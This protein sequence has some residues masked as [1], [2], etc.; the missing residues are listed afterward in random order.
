MLRRQLHQQSEAH[1]KAKPLTSSNKMAYQL[2]ELVGKSLDP[3]GRWS[4]R[5]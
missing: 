2:G 5:E 4:P 3:M 1:G